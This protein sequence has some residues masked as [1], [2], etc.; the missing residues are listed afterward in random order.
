MDLNL[1]ILFVTIVVVSILLLAMMRKRR[2]SLSSKQQR[3]FREHWKQ[4]EDFQ[5][6]DPHY[7]I[8]YADKLLDK[9]LKIKGYNG[10]VGEKLKKAQ[11]LFSDL[12]GLWSAHKLR[13]RVAHELNIQPNERETASALNSFKK[14]LRDLGVEF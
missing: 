8:L 9:A 3:F 14:A 2:K 5:K 11:A 13:N 10:S 6:E 7:V 4:I 1:V 12:N